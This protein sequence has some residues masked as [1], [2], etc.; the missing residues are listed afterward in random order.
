MTGRR[1]RGH[2]YPG[3]VKAAPFPDGWKEH[4]PQNLIANPRNAWIES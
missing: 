4:E 2:T 1:T 3:L